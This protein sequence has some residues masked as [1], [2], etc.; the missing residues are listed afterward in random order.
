MGM[1]LTGIHLTGMHLTG[2]HLTDP[3]IS[4]SLGAIISKGGCDDYSRIPRLG[5][6]IRRGL[7]ISIE[8][9]VLHMARFGEGT[10]TTATL[11]PR[12]SV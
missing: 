9:W 10:G 8:W 3:E 2:M 7:P 5:V 12:F 1:H 6:L 4:N 11:A